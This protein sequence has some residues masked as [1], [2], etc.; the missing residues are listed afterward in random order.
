MMYQLP[1]YDHDERYCDNLDDEERQKMG[2]F[3]DKRNHEALGVG[4][5]REK[6]SPTTKWVRVCLT[7]R[8]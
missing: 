2:D 1:I 7:N 8:L 3:C 4:D 5:I 6:T